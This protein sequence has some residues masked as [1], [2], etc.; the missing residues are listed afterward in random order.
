MSVIIT[1]N[2]FKK[3]APRVNNSSVV[4]LC[5][6]DDDDD[7]DRFPPRA[8]VSG[9]ALLT[10]AQSDTQVNHIDNVKTHLHKTTISSSV[11]LMCI[12]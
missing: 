7:D 9:C 11:P 4:I 12:F 8:A 2:I 5:G 1:R 6:G 10:T 3:D